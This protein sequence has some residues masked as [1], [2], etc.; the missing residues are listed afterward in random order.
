ME[1]EDV[2]PERHGI[3]PDAALPHREQAQ[4]ADERRGGREERP[5][6]PLVAATPVHEPVEAD[7]GQEEER[8]ERRVGVPVRGSL[9]SEVDEAEHGRQHH[10]VREPGHRKAGPAARTKRERARAEHERH[11]GQ[12]LERG[13]RASPLTG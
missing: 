3:A 4:D 11:R 7:A 8:D 6:H 1:G 2:A 5:R 9:W 12:V 13:E 10:E